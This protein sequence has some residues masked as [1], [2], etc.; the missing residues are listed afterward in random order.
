MLL[1]PFWNAR[2]RRL[3]VLWRLASQLLVFGALVAIQMILIG[4]AFG[5][6]S[7]PS[8]VSHL[9]A[10]APDM[11][12]LSGVATLL[13]ALGSLWV[14]GRLLDRRPFSGF[15]FRLDRRWWGDLAF[16]LALGMLLMT[17][18]FLVELAAGW[19]TIRSFLHTTPRA[20][21][22]GLVFAYSLVLFICVGIYEEA[23]A[24]GYLLR[25]LSEGLNLRFV[26]PRVAIILAWV[27]S[28]LIFGALHAGNPNA[29]LV[30]TINLMVAGL[31][32]GLSYVLTGELAIPIGLHITWNLFQGNVYGFPVS[33][34]DFTQATVIAVT[35]GGPDWCTGGAFGPEAG[36]IGLLATMAG[37]ALIAWWVRRRER[38]ALDATL[39]HPPGQ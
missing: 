2:E 5:L 28:S 14:A 15:G 33:G 34:G 22:F 3:R 39:G 35:Q 9:Q 13:A 19:V 21:P 32:L 12:A 37:M 27:I 25:N 38:L 31:F 8:S 16:G 23:L 29:T 26:G 10:D 7:A 24:R 4:V 20:Q 18:I 11:T 36:L 30:S 6:T 17:A 1:K